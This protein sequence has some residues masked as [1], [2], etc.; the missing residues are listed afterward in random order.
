MP[1][2]SCSSVLGT[3]V[4]AEAG[5]AVA[6]VGGM[7]LVMGPAAVTLHGTK[8]AMAVVMSGCRGRVEGL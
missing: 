1:S 2:G 3:A 4:V 7:L 5:V 6:V 8:T